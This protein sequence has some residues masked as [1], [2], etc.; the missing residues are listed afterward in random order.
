M[1]WVAKTKRQVLSLPFSA[2][3][4]LAGDAA[5]GVAAADRDWVLC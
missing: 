4:L 1:L 5:P 2:G 3:A